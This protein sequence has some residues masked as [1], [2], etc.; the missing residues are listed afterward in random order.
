MPD[1]RK[2]S[3]GETLQRTSD[4]GNIHSCFS[5]ETMAPFVS[6]FTLGRRA[7]AKQ[8]DSVVRLLA[9]LAALACVAAPAAADTW[10]E[11]TAGQSDRAFYTVTSNGMRLQLGCF[12]TAGGLRFTLIGGAT[13]LPEVSDLMVWIELPDG[14][15][16]RYP[17]TG[18]DHLGGAE[19]ALIGTLQLGRQGMEFFAAGRELS[20]DGPPGQE[21]F[22]SGMTGTAAAR[23]DFARTCGL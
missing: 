15:S 3:G 16:G 8:G 18:I 10:V 4:L 5:V 7:G 2:R 1:R 11:D 6:L 14:R 9:A 22:R 23:Q 19:N 12:G 20:I 13:T 17:M 21:I